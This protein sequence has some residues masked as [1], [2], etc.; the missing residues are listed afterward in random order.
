MKRAIYFVLNLAARVSFVIILILFFSFSYANPQRDETNLEIVEGENFEHLTLS[1]G[2]SQGTVKCIFQDRRGFLWFGTLNGLNRYDGYSFKVFISTPENTSTISDNNIMNIVEDKDGHL[3]IGTANGLNRFN[4]KTE[5]FERFFFVDKNQYNNHQ[6]IINDPRITNVLNFNDNSIINICMDKTKG[7][8]TLW[9]GI[10]LGLIELDIV[11][12]KHKHYKPAFFGDVP[13]LIKD[14]I[15]DNKGNL[16][17]S[18]NY[19]T[20]GYV[21][22]FNKRTKEFK[23]NKIITGLI[24]HNRVENITKMFLDSKNHLWVTT[25]F[26]TFCF[27]INTFD[28]I[29]ERCDFIPQ[30]I[31][32]TDI[33][34]DYESN[35]WFTTTGGG[36]NQVDFKNR[37]FYIRINDVTNAN[38]LSYN[39]LLSGL[40]DR[41]NNLWIGTHGMGVDK[42]SNYS[43]RFNMVRGG[44]KNCEIMSVRNIYEDVSGN[45]WISG[46]HGFMIYKTANPKL[47]PYQLNPR[48]YYT[49]SKYTNRKL[50][51]ELQDKSKRLGLNY[52]IR[53]SLDNIVYCMISDHKDK[54]VL[55]LGLE[56]N[57]LLRYYINDFVFERIPFDKGEKSIK[58]SVIFAIQYDNSGNLWLGTERG[59][60]RFNYEKNEYLFFGNNPAD[61][62]SITP[63]IVKVI[64]KDRKGLLWIG[65]DNGGL[66][67]LNEADL[68]FTQYS[69]NSKIEHS[70]SSNSV[71]S[72]LEDKKGRLWV[73]TNNGLNLMDRESGKFTSY[74]T[75]NGLSNNTVYGILED[76]EG[77]LWMSTNKG[78]SRFN[79]ET[80][81][82]YNYS[83]KDGLQNDEFNTNAYFKTLSGELFFGGVNGFNHFF[84]SEIFKTTFK[85]NIV[86]TEFSIFS[87]PVRVGEKINDKIILK[88][89]IN[90]TEEIT[91]NYD[92]NMI[93]IEYALLSFTNPGNIKYKYRMLNLNDNWITTSDRKV[94]FTNLA[95]GEYVFEVIGSSS[96]GNWSDETATLKIII[97]PPFWE[98]WWFRT[99]VFLF[100][101]TVIYLLYKRRIRDIQKRQ[102]ELEKLV[103]ERTKDLTIEKEKTEL[104]YNKSEQLL[105]NILPEPIAERL[106]KGEQPIADHFDE[107]SVIFIDIADFTKL[108][109]KSTPQKMVNMLNEIFTHFDRIAAK[110]GLEK[111]KTIGDCY[112]AAAGI[113]VH[114]ADHAEAVALM[115]VESMET[116]RNYR[117]ED[118]HEIKF[119]LGLDCGPIVAGVIGKQKFIYDL[120][121][122]MV[123]T[124]SRMEAN[125]I[126]DRIQCTE[127]FAKKIENKAEELGIIFE[128]R[129]EI[130]VKGKGMMKTYFLHRA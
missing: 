86:F 73:G 105:L 32:V 47:E 28:L 94:T 58:G 22:N 101:A 126:V 27:D 72:I 123:N 71:L 62:N 97:T 78:L 7:S 75:E 117:S 82:F 111:I 104:L 52:Q 44:T 122:D 38:S 119:R 43:N 61:K 10:N 34:E 114:R 129:G 96:E 49:G 56:G 11:T 127:R 102:I 74:T 18:Y 66:N 42:L 77:W 31:L 85:S 121:G 40:I 55:W 37:K 29:K 60:N 128:E 120:W 87:K 17:L 90:E 35:L 25:N 48:L 109:S 21:V 100:I 20:R 6:S 33:L 124:A 8:N 50:Y 88:Q 57:S 107:A 69:Q 39:A 108:S 45:I 19:D 95:P 12:K 92:E 113:P 53:S 24:D 4:P 23:L 15:D 13:Y 14:I 5:T 68:T 103:E 99:L 70:I 116:M 106:M 80:K 112:M 2:L 91:L 118:G 9:L 16:I 130:A 84:P 41:S 59:V 89:S 54:N 26:R 30:N 1:D 76:E 98:T 125:G 63:G 79:P 51:K 93:T 65:T 81:I 83:Q 67:R 115:A 36:V 64:Y 110:H 3:W 46:Y